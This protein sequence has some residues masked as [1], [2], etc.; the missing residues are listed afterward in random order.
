[1]NRMNRAPSGVL[2]PLVLAIAAGLGAAPPVHAQADASAE[3]AALKVELEAMRARIAALEAQVAEAS[4]PAAGAVASVEAMPAVEPGPGFEAATTDGA[5]AFEVGGRIHY[6]FY[7]NND[8]TVPT[9]GG[10]EFRRAR[11]NIEGTAGGWSYV[12]QTELSGGIADL[13]DVYLQRNVGDA[14]LLIGQFKPFRSLDE[15]TS[16][17]DFVVLERGFGSG[18]TLFSAAQWQQGV[19]LLSE[20]SAGTLGFSVFTLREDNTPRNEGWGAAARGTWRP[21]DDG[22]RLVHL[23]ASYSVEDGGDRTPARAF[24]AAYGG[25]RGA[26]A[27]L[28]ESAAG[29]AF[30]QR[31]AGVEFA[32]R[33]GGFHWQSEWQRA[34]VAG[35]AGDG[36]LETQ[37]LQVGYLFGGMRA[38]DRGD[39]VFDSPKDAAGLWELVARMD[40]IRLR[41]VDNAEA[42]RW[43]LGVNWYATDDVRFM[44]N[45]TQGRDEATGDEPSQ[46]ALR[47]QY[48]F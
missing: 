48:V 21:L 1:M 38:Y 45:W 47:A 32:G 5:S 25:R 41:E 33:M 26:E 15:L 11:F 24:E 27:L 37:Y 6:D 43:V 39:G 40:R 23:G 4:A 22:D 31:S 30:E 19:G 10:S 16:S 20:R 8:D 2:A 29:D 7:A 35:L 44:L 17:N 18:S 14:A 9:R 13:R 12:L 3:L 42:L 34:T 46:L 28:F 36:R